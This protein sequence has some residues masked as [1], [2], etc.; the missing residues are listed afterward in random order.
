MHKIHPKLII[1]AGANGSGKTTLANIFLPY[2]KIK[3]FINADEIARGISPLHPETR[4]VM[5]GK[6]VLKLIH[7]MIA[8][9]ESFAIESTL[10]GNTL[11]S[12]LKTAKKHEYHI[13]MFYMYTTDVEINLKRIKNR[14]KHGGHHVPAGDVRRR[15]KRSVLNL[16]NLYFDLCDIIRIYDNSGARHKSVAFKMQDDMLVVKTEKQIWEQIKKRGRVKKK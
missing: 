11:A 3:Q 4:K 13:D 10:S 5:A 1:F 15:Y 2:A 6:L 16:I 12:I 8:K 14:V 7:E 9:G